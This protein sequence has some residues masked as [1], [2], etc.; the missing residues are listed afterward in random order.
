MKHRRSNDDYFR[1]FQL[2]IDR[3]IFLLIWIIILGLLIFFFQNDIQKVWYKLLCKDIESTTMY[4]NDLQLAHFEGNVKILN[5]Q[6]KRVYEGMYSDGACNGKGVLYDEHGHLLYEGEFVENVMEDKNGKLHFDND[7]MD[8]YVGEVHENKAHGKGRAYKKSDEQLTIVYEGEFVNGKFQGKGI[9]FD[10]QGEIDYEGEFLN[11][12]RHGQ[13]ILYENG[14][15]TRKVYQGEFAFDLPQGVGTLY[16]TF[17]KAYYEGAMYEGHINFTSFLP[18]TLEDITTCFLIPY[19]IYVYQDKTAIVYQSDLLSLVFFPKEPLAI[20]KDE[21][22]WTL[23]QGQELKDVVMSSVMMVDNN[24]DDPNTGTDPDKILGSWQKKYQPHTEKVIMDFY[25]VIALHMTKNSIFQKYQ[26]S[27]AKI[28]HGNEIYELTNTLP[29]Q[30]CKRVFYPVTEY[31]IGYGYPIFQNHL[32]YT[33]M[34]EEKG[35]SDLESELIAK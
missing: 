25:D 15:N 11:G 34:L 3:R 18:S 2:Y 8:V 32:L 30:I 26:K 35:K 1:F 6:G 24:I 21:Q 4:Y 27:V 23:T 31:S 19:Q 7:V 14:A 20:T 33:L 5:H 28:D 17:G 10:E 13:G 29:M 16:D 9:Y 22:I 12:M